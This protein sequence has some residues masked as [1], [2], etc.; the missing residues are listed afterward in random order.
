MARDFQRSRVYKAER[1]DAFTA[2]SQ[3]VGSIHDV[4]AYV[5][6]I[7]SSR[8]WRNRCPVKSVQVWDG[9]GTR[10][11]YGGLFCSGS[12]FGWGISLPRWARTHWVILH[13]L[14][15]VITEANGYYDDGHP[16][17]GREFCATFLELTRRW[18]GTDAAK[19]LKQS[20]KDHKVKYTR[21]N[22]LTEDEIERQ[23]AQL[24]PL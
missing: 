3:E 20:F 7:T 18:I 9:R 8:W 10:I 11:A 12:K 24:Q 13:E 4:R 17:H 14:A 2:Y 22:R 1:A 23:I 5:D 19:A 16:A 21:K 15:H 6:K